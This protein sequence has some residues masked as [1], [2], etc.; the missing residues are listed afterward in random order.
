MHSKN[1]W[2]DK[3]DEWYVKMKN[4]YNSMRGDHG[5]TNGKSGNESLHVVKICEPGNGRGSGDADRCSGKKIE[6]SMLRQQLE[7]AR[8]KLGSTDDLLGE[9]LYYKE[10]SGGK[11]DGMS[12]EDYIK[13]LAIDP[14]LIRNQEKYATDRSVAQFRSTVNLPN[15]M[16]VMEPCEYIPWRLRR[17]QLVPVCDPMQVPEYDNSWFS[18]G[19]T[20]TWRS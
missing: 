2:F 5:Q 17:P 12:Y 4:K 11:Y 10:P 3:V 1:S 14:E 15:K 20:L 19:A 16:G 18:N 13:T 7:Y 9:K 6:S 8:N